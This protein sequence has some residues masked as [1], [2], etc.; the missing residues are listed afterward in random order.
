MSTPTTLLARLDAAV[1]VQRRREDEAEA[2]EDLI[3]AL[4]ADCDEEELEEHLATWHESRRAIED[5]IDALR[6]AA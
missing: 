6:G 1:L 5:A 3:E 4:A 2:Y